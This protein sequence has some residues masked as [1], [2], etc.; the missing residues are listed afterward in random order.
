MDSD[1]FSSHVHW[2][3]S[4][5]SSAESGIPLSTNNLPTLKYMCS[6]VVGG[7]VLPLKKRMP[8]YSAGFHAQNSGHSLG[9][10]CWLRWVRSLILEGQLLRAVNEPACHWHIVEEPLQKLKWRRRGQDLAPA[11]WQPT[12][13]EFPCRMSIV[14]SP[15]LQPHTLA[16]I[17][18]CRHRKTL[19]RGSAPRSPR[20]LWAEFLSMAAV[21]VTRG[22]WML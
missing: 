19:G 22:T 10:Q 1:H 21:K 14:L 11:S 6:S 9:L 17:Q 18:L 5:T 20:R 2:D 13:G 4:D 12:D 16:R 7:L 8:S 3:N 15:T